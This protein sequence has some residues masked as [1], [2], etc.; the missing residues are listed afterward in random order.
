KNQH[1]PF[2][3]LH[4]LPPINTTTKNRETHTQHI[5]MPSL[6]VNRFATLSIAPPDITVLVT[7]KQGTVQVFAD[8]N[9]LRDSGGEE[10]CDAIHL[11]YATAAGQAGLSADELD[12]MVLA[13][14][15]E[16]ALGEL[17]D[18]TRDMYE[19]AQNSGLTKD[20]E[21]NCMRILREVLVRWSRSVGGGYLA[22]DFWQG[23]Y[24]HSVVDLVEHMLNNEHRSVFLAFT[25]K[26]EAQIHRFA[27]LYSRN[28]SL[29][30]EFSAAVHTVTVGDVIDAVE[31][32]L[33]HNMPD[34]T[35]L[36]DMLLWELQVWRFANVPDADRQK[37]FH[38]HVKALNEKRV[39]NQDISEIA[40]RYNQACK[41]EWIRRA[42]EAKLLVTYDQH[43]RLRNQLEATEITVAGHE[44]S[45][46]SLIQDN[47][48]LTNQNAAL[49]TSVDSLTNQNA[50]LQ[51][52]VDSLTTQNAALQTSV[53]SLTN[54]NAAL[55]TS[56]DSL[57]NQ[58]AAL[59]TSVD[60]LTTQNAALQ[61]SVDSLTNQNAALQTSVDSLTNQNAAL[62]TSVNS[63]TN[64]NAALQTSVDS[65]TNQNAALKTALDSLTDRYDK[66]AEKMDLI[67]AGQV[68][69][70]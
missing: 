2:V 4:H 29:L 32:W 53:D 66:L 27:H 10:L 21:K 58:N 9:S 46:A 57:T 48:T 22:R 11:V 15:R 54:Q 52:S 35:M 47:A 17:S 68:E 41:Q 50:A 45:I 6:T 7:K 69:K 8:S 59:Q 61:T 31:L 23:L 42:E 36:R 34:A 40:E 38:E 33:A 5:T 19:R 1:R 55:Q 51:T 37:E 3:P 49:Q 14:G 43:D 13:A 20:Q 25:G 18:G 63:L 70:A 28:P 44:A 65:L 30:S 64:Q 16:P 56:V 39:H 67:L 12:R 26:G 60:S 62:Q 24:N